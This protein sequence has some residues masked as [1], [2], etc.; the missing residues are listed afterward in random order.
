MSTQ[1]QT[2]FRSGLRFCGSCLVTVLCW[3]VWLGLGASLVALIYIAAAH[4]LPVPDFVLR[5][6]EAE[7]AK[8]N[9]TIKFGRAR[10][11]PTGKILLED[12]EFRS[13]RFEEPLLT[14]RVLYLRR[15]F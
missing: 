2:W 6:A 11:D 12:V 1:P 5:R 13:R 7:L 8:V 15:D 3:A 4:E 10:F 9:L 14:C